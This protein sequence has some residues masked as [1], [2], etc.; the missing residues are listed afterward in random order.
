MLTNDNNL[1]KKNFPVL[2]TYYHGFYRINYTACFDTFYCINIRIL[3][4]K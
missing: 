4:I 3:T 2:N 1:F